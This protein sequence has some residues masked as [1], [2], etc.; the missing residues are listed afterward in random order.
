ML[1]QGCEEK[2]AFSICDSTFDVINVC[3]DE[4]GQ[5][6]MESTMGAS[7]WFCAFIELPPNL[8]IGDSLL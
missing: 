3:G 5:L 2:V 1:L 6:R 8:L 4:A 7:Q